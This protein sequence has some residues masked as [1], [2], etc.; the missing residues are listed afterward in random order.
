MPTHARTGLPG[1]TPRQWAPALWRGPTLTAP[2][3][4]SGMITCGHCG[5]RFQAHKPVRRHEYPYYVCGGY[6]AAGRAVCDGL[7]V[8]MAYLDD[9]MLDGIQKASI[10]SSIGTCSGGDWTN[11]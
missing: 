5:K 10:A 3:L 8:P 11:S 6:V 4:L 2:Y 9:A 7:R 1:P